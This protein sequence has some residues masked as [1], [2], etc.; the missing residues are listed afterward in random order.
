M[1]KK[2]PIL[3]AGDAPNVVGGLARIA[4]DITTLLWQDREELGIEVF[5]AGIRYDGSPWPWR[6]F[7]LHDE[8][9]WGKGDWKKVWQ[10]IGGEESGGVVISIWDPARC[11]ELADAKL[12]HADLWGYFA[13]DSETEFGGFGGPAA[14]A[15]QRYQRILAYGGWGLSVLQ[16]VAQ[17]GKDTKWLPHGME[18]AKW[19]NQGWKERETFLG[20]KG[21]LLGCV[22]TN[23]PRKDLA[24]LFAAAQKLREKGNGWESLHLWLHTDYLV[25][26]WSVSELAE[27]YGW[28]S[29]LLT[30]TREISDQEMAE[31]LGRCSVTLA[32]GRGE[33][34]GYPIIE[35]LA[36]G[37]PVVHGEFGGGQEW[38]PRKEWVVEKEGYYVDGTYALMRPIYNVDK[39]VEALAGAGE[40][41]ERD[42]ETTA[43]YCQGAVKNLDWQALWPRWK[44]WVKAGLRAREQREKE[45]RNE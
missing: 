21:R 38:V 13:I 25:K 44:S 10:W 24:L 5:Q 20:T 17:K 8:D 28:N 9:N 42:A 29:E 43:A 27:L 18:I 32:C 37:T 36:A 6:V 2:V 15:V 16:K 12:K 39:V 40:E 26:S 7:P 35:S 4:R 45:K 31:M 1:R 3:V 23:Q 11:W 14:E 34:F 30:V 19:Q 22:A 33:G 41:K